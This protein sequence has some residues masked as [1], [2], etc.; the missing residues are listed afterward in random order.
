MIN[1]RSTLAA[2]AL[3]FGGA[4]VASAQQPTPAPAQGAHQQR[5]GR[6]ARNQRGQF[7][8]AA[9]RHQLFKGITLS[10]AEKASVKNVQ[11]KYALQMKA[12]R[13]QLKPQI[14]AAREARQ[15][16]D[17]AALK[18]IWQKSGA[19]REQIKNLLESEK[20]DLRAALTPANQ[21]K[22]DANVKQFEQRVAKRAT[23]DW[24]KGDRATAAQ[25]PR[26]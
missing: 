4:V 2:A 25:K 17:T 5:A 13:E 9:I 8:P 1:I 26:G 10:D 24:K 12:I 18:A 14:Q 19:E 7:R 23:R 15:R 22:F 6:A 11:A 20:N 3:V 16:G 21:V